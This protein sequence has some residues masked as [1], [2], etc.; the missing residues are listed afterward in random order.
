GT[1]DVAPGNNTISV[2][3]SGDVAGGVWPHMVVKVAGATVISASVNSAIPAVYSGTYNNAGSGGP[4]VLTVSFDNDDSAGSGDRHL[5]PQ[6]ASV[7][8][9]A[10]NLQGWSVVS[11]AGSVQQAQGG[12]QMQGCYTFTRYFGQGALQVLAGS[13]G[14]QTLYV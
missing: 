6:T 3:A 12:N 4:K 1:V 13:T 7:D 14:Y 9:G 11:G 10:G 2:K 8:D 5:R